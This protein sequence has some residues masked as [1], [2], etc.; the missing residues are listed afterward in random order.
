MHRPQTT[1]SE[2]DTEREITRDRT[3]A[4]THDW[5]VGPILQTPTG[6]RTS[7]GAQSF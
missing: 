4:T 3:Q 6:N 2:I 7:S 5:T 1:Q